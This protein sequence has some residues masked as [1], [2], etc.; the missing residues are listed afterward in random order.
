MKKILVIDDDKQ[1]RELLMQILEKKGEYQVVTAH[2]GDIGMKL[3]RNDP[4]DLVITDIFMPQKMG[5]E[6]IT[7]LHGAFSD[8][9]IIAISGGD[10]IGPE[11]YTITAE[12]IGAD[13]SLNK[14]F[15]MKEM[16]DNVR[17]LIGSS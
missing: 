17:D 11:D 14:P 2:N 1:F 3:F 4:F 16:L 10:F 9:K 7:E 5:F 6:V 13:R 8:T 15:S 12:L